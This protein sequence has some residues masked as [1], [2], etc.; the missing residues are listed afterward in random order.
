MLRKFAA[1]VIVPSCL[2]A[3][4]GV[5]LIA[6]RLIANQRYYQI[7]ALWCLVPFLWGVWAMLTPTTWFPRRL[8]AWGAILGVIAGVLGAFVIDVPLRVMG[9]SLSVGLKSAAV[10]L[11]AII[12]YLLW[13]I[14]GPVYRALGPETP[15]GNVVR[16]A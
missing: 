10:V 2:I 16:A 1:G 9:L 13:M 8:P 15:A 11:A 12:Y 6:M 7:A 3:I 5:V 4:G 14:V